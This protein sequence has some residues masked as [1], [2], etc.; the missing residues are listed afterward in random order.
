MSSVFLTFYISLQDFKKILEVVNKCVCHNAFRHIR[1]FIRIA[2]IPPAVII[3]YIV[4]SF[5]IQNSVSNKEDFFRNSVQYCRR[6]LNIL[7]SQCHG[8]E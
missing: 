5:D 2:F 4:C 6:I 1:Y 7:S 3:F 8:S